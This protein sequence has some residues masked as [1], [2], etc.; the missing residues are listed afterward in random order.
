MRDLYLDYNTIALKLDALAGQMKHDGYEALAIILRGGAFSG[1]HLAFLTALPVYFLRYDRTVGQ[2]HWVG[3][4]PTQQKVLLCEDFAG[5]G[6][7]LIRS[8]QFLVD[9][10]YDVATCV[11]CV[12]RLSASVPDYACFWLQAEEARIILPWERYRANHAV[13]THPGLPDHAYEKVAWDMDGVFVDDVEGW[14]YAEDLEQAL[15]TRDALLPADYAPTIG[16]GDCIVTGRPVEDEERT[17]GWLAR[18]HIELPLYMRDDG[19][20]SPTPRTTALWKAAKAKELGCTHFVESNAEQAAVIA[21]THPEMRVV[22]WNMGRPM[23]I[24]AAA[25]SFDRPTMVPRHDLQHQQ[26]ADG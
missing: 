4:A 14:R 10:G 18:H 5:S 16:P 15:Q 19:I 26:E 1:I 20:V 3:P 24:Q 7:T 11:V 22:W 17:R 6:Q 9:E 2:A 13:D 12:D 23:V 25:T 8:R 21:S